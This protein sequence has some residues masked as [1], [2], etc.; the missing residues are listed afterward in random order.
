MKRIV[1]IILALCLAA[2][3]LGAAAEQ[4]TNGLTVTGELELEYATQFKVE[5]CEGG[6]NLITNSD[7]ARFLT[8][9]EGASVPEGIDE[10]IVTLQMPLTNLL[11]SSTPTTSLINAIGALD[12]VTMTTQE[13]SGWYIDD[14]KAAMDAGKLTYIGTYKE[15]DFELLASNPPTFSVFSTM[16]DSVPDVAEKLTELGIPYMRDTSTYEGHPL[17]RME[18][19]KLYGILLGRE[20]EAQAH[21][22]AQKAMVEAI[23][24]ESTGKTVA[25][26]YITSKGD[27]YTRNAGDYMVKMLELAG[28]EYI[29]SD[30]NPEKSGTQKISA[31]DFYMLA[32]DAD[33]IIYIWSMGGKPETMEAF[34]ER[35][36]ILPDFKAVK[37]GNVWFTTPD[38]FQI[39]D[40]LGAMIVDFNKVLTNEDD[41]VTAFTYLF[42]LP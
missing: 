8:I 32:S 29:L 38:Y 26:F 1:S 15:P 40:T 25:M 33:Y 19:I 21:F 41:S 24:A 12:C 18:W 14:V 5:F 31:E 23:G 13:Y 34:L 28:G 16:L 7:G 20:E 35:S 9:P 42:K 4:T 37:D 3:M 10:D 11:I 22:D 17:G 6:Y 30:L 36:T 2:L 39:N 27:I